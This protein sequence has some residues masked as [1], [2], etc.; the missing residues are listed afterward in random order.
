MSQGQPRR[1]REGG[2]VPV[3]DRPDAR[4]RLLADKAATKL[5]AE[6]VALAEA[7]NKPDMAIT[8]D[9]VA[10]AV[11]AAARLNQERP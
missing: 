3:Q 10:D 9:G 11:T 8:P 5:D 6:G 4:E 2:G 7:R 1:P